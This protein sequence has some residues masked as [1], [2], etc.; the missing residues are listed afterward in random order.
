MWLKSF[1]KGPL[2]VFYFGGNIDCLKDSLAKSFKVKHEQV[3]WPNN[4]TDKISV[5]MEEK[6]KMVHIKLSAIIQAMM[7]KAWTF[8]EISDICLM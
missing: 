5:K 1:E 2:I 4:Y 7:K 8:Y 3:I 6:G